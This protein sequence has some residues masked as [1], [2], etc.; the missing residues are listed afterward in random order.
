[1]KR[2]FDLNLFREGEEAVCYSVKFRG[3]QHSEPDKFINEQIYNEPESFNDI[4]YRL[5]NMLNEHLFLPPMLK[6]DEGKRN[7]WVVAIRTMRPKHLRWYGLRYNDRILI[8]GNGGLKNTRT[9]QQDPQLHNCVKDLQYVLRCIHKRMNQ[10]SIEFDTNN[11]RISG[12][13]DFPVEQFSDVLYPI[14]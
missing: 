3:E 12:N 1:M 4:N 8:L 5:D 11:N 10:N 13:L 9:Y 14:D 6:L 7:D 2:S